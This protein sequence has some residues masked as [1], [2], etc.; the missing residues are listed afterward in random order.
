[1]DTLSYIIGR[2]SAGGG[3]GSTPSWSDVTDKPFDS[4]GAGLTTTSGTLQEA[5][6]VYSELVSEYETYTSNLY[7]NNLEYGSEWTYQTDGSLPAAVLFIHLDCGDFNLNVGDEEETTS[8]VDPTLDLHDEDDNIWHC[9]IDGSD[10]LHVSCPDQPDLHDALNVQ[11]EWKENQ[12]IE[13]WSESDISKNQHPSDTF[14]TSVDEEG[15]IDSIIHSEDYPWM[16]TVDFTYYADFGNGYEPFRVFEDNVNIATGATLTDGNDV[17][18]EISLDDQN[19]SISTK[20]LDYPITG[21]TLNDGAELNVTY[22]KYVSQEVVHQLPVKYIPLDGSTIYENNGVLSANLAIASYSDYL[23]GEGVQIGQLADG[24]DNYYDVYAPSPTVVGITNTLGSGTA[25]ADIEINGETTTLYAPTIPVVTANASTLTTGEVIGSIEI[26][27]V[28]TTFRG[29]Y[30]PRKTSQ[31]VNDAD[32]LSSQDTGI[33]NTLSSG[34]AIG[35]LT[36][37]GVTTTLYAPAGGGSTDWADITNKPN[38]SKGTNATTA[39]VVIGNGQ[40]NGQRAVVISGG[41]TASYNRANGEGSIFIGS[42]SDSASVAS[43]AN[44]VVIGRNGQA[45]GDNSVSIGGGYANKEGIISIGY[46]SGGGYAPNTEHDYNIYFGRNLNQYAPSISYPVNIRGQYNYYATSGTPIVDYLDILGNGQSFQTKNNAEATDYSGNKYLAGDIYV[47]VTDWAN[48]QA[49]SVKLANI[50][51]AP[52]TAGTYTLQVV[53]DSDGNPT[54][55][56]V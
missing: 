9:Y 29:E 30:V 49:N 5:V 40:A 2:N 4:I 14:K 31:L 23:G 50:P 45:R 34:T 25:I 6:P 28:T 39:G 51:T 48:P 10:V 12:S 13:T 19:Y 55:S 44:S 11:F 26:D 27:G 24:N 22:S 56:W 32:F 3:S 41:G 37:Y 33:T 8:L 20:C 7:P 1:M 53:V 36:I 38:I 52:T 35:D 42:S 18:W 47:N 43:G 54:Y 46:G 21:A 17:R 16:S 15:E